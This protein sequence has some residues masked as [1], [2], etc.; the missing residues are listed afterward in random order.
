LGFPYSL[1]IFDLD[2]TLV[3]SV[4]DIAEAVNRTLAQWR[5]SGIDEDTVRN[6]LGDGSRKLIESAFRHSGRELDV[7]EVMPVFMRHYQACLLLDP[8]LYPGV[9][10]TLQA[11]RDRGVPMAI[12]SNKPAQFIRPL[13]E[14]LQIDDY[15]EVTL[16]GDSLPESKPSGMPL[17]YL[18]D[19]FG[20]AAERCLMVGDSS[21]DLHSALDAGMPVALVSYGYTRNLD[22]E[23]APATAIVD[24][25]REILQL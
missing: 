17:G 9:R 1:V 10:E 2:G 18:A 8:R 14:A 11:L 12:C 19:K 21:A 20:E 7:Q 3:D 23:S 16:G 24:D 22:L 13:L 15:F 4:S 6:W 5:L 25:I